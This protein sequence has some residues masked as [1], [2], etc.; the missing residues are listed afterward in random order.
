LRSRL[1][2]GSSTTQTCSGLAAQNNRPNPSA[3]SQ[4][5]SDDW[6]PPERTR[7][8][9]PLRLPRCRRPRSGIPRTIR[10]HGFKL[11][12]NRPVGSPTFLPCYPRPRSLGCGDGRRFALRRGGNP[13]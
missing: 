10:R 3:A 4:D 12:R 11:G 9:I 7:P 5:P 2:R 1:R 13:R 8:V 6:R